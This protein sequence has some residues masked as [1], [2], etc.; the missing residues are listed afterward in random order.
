MRDLAELGDDRVVELTPVVAVD[1]QP[2]RGVAV[3]VLDAIDVEQL[4]AFPAGDHHRLAGEILLH[5]G[6]RVPEELRV[7]LEETRV[8]SRRTGTKVESRH[9]TAGVSSRYA[10]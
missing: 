6:E 2:Q 9:R 10:T 8:G 1:V 5:L 7:L 3:V 4:D